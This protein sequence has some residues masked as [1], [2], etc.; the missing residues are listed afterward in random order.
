[1]FLSQIFPSESNGISVLFST[2]RQQ[3]IHEF[4]F[5]LYKGPPSSRLVEFQ[6]FTQLFVLTSLLLCHCVILIEE[7]LRSKL[8]I[9]CTYFCVLSVF[10]ILCT[11][12]VDRLTRQKL[13]GQKSLLNV[14]FASRIAVEK[15][16]AIP[17]P[18]LST[19]PIFVNLVRDFFFPLYARFQGFTLTL[20][21][22]NFTISMWIFLYSLYLAL[23]GCQQFRHPYLL[24]LIIVL[25]LI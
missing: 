8:F 22:H 1:M 7:H 16:E 2:S 3:V 25:L 24:V 18:I 4:H 10:L 15:S 17:I 11:H 19:G 12:L 9:S 6:N 21:L 14:F 23:S 13:L 20:A 5:L